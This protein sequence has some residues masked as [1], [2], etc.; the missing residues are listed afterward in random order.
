MEK[1]SDKI[2][3]YTGIVLEIIIL[4]IAVFLLNSNIKEISDII[5]AIVAVINLIIVIVFFIVSD[6]QR[7]SEIKN[8]N[9]QDWYK[10][11]IVSE[12]LPIFD[13]FFK[14]SK[15]DIEAISLKN[16]SS[17]QEKEEVFEE[18]LQDFSKKLDEIVQGAY[19]KI[20]VIS[21]E[22]AKKIQTE[23]QE[24]EDEYSKKLEIII[25]CIGETKNEEI[26]NLIK[27]ILNKQATIF[28]IFY[29][30]GKDIKFIG[31]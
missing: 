31:D 22:L 11:Y 10:N 8:K 14:E 26:N 3:V 30:Y 9:K 27:F 6:I 7:N 12:F 1:I 15:K 28:R 5:Q 16:F 24:L 29:E 23:M 4:I 19:L 2:I 13:S 25:F 21:N 17:E 20:N 18:Y